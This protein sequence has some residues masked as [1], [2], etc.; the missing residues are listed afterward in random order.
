[1][2]RKPPAIPPFTDLL[3]VSTFER[4]KPKARRSK[5]GTYKRRDMRSEH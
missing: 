1:M 2:K 3:I 5:P 4:R